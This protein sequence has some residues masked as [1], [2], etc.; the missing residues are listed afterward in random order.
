MLDVL[1]AI[2]LHF[3]NPHLACMVD[4]LKD[5]VLYLTKLT[6]VKVFLRN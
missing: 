3:V 5:F 4:N 1:T 2:C 6:M